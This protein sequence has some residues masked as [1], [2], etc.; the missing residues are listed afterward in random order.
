MTLSEPLL[1]ALI[2]G[3]ATIAVAL[4]QALTALQAA[5]RA[6][7]DVDQIRDS[8]VAALAYIS[9]L[10][11]HIASEAPPPPPDPPADLATALLLRAAERR[12]E[13]RGG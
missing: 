7:D 2:G 13:R 1:L 10:R 6:E 12:T 5:H 9:E 8:L 11:A 4:V 3:V